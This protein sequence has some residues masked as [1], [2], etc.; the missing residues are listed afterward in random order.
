MRIERLI[1][2][3]VVVAAAVLA[4]CQD[5]ERTQA[6]MLLAQLRSIVIKDSCE[7][8]KPLVAKLE[9]LGLTDEELRRIRHKCVQ[10]HRSLIAAE[11][12]QLKARQV[13]TNLTGEDLDKKLGNADAIVV[14]EAIERSNRELKRAKEL[15]PGCEQATRELELR[16]ASSHK[17][18]P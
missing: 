18:T 5:S 17:L 14:A 10:A 15:F 8:R 16:F 11:E 2:T 3:A 1:V 12:Q 13:L 4:G 9:A 6:R 7:V